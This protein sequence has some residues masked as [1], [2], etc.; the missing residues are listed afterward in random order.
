MRFVRAGS[1]R[2]VAAFALGLLAVGAAACRRAPPTSAAADPPPGPRALRDVRYEATADRLARGRYLTEGVLQCFLC[3]SDRDWSAPGA[4]PV[5]GRKGA[6]HVWEDRPWLV[7]PNITPDRETG[8][9]TWTDDMFARAIREGIGHDGR[10]LHPQMWY[11]SFRSLSD[12]D[13]ASIV[14]YLRTL[15]PVH[16]ALPKTTLPQGRQIPPPRQLVSEVKWPAQTDP[17]S[18]GAYLVRVADCIGCHTAFEA[19]QIPGFFGGGN[20]VT[21][22]GRPPVF[23]S[24]ITFDPS[25]IPYYDAALFKETIR[26][27]RVRARALSGAMP[28][29]VFRNMTD[30]DLDAIFAYLRSRRPVR[31]NVSNTDPPT[32]CP[33]CGQTHGLGERNHVQPV[34]EVAIAPAILHE[35]EGV[36]RMNDGFTL[37]F[38]VKDGHLVVEFDDGSPSIPVT[39][40]SQTDFVAL[41]DVL[42]FVRDG[43]GRVTGV[44]DNTDEFG[45]KVR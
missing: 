23:S 32:P 44:I 3:H 34:A 45:Q 31:H 8:A 19:P 24:N 40:I 29:I 10:V 15:P 17:V 1:V 13:V 4:P 41:P 30:E 39:A 14:V 33:V 28:W 42:T 9:G 6:G 43:H 27:G 16:N 22:G 36:Y 38:S 26:T 20:A 7:S 18:R 37:A 21:R 25:G 11:A 2:R 35:Y 5:A 12:D